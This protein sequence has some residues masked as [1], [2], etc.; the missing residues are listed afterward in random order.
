MA[1]RFLANP[2]VAAST[3]FAKEQF[4]SKKG[5]NSDEIRAAFLEMQARKA[6]R[7][8]KIAEGGSH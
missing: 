1:V 6:N 7:V 5:L 3:K 8:I 2:K 4:L